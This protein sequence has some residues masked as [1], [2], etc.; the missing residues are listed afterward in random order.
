MRE[1]TVNEIDKVSGGLDADGVSVGLGALALGV[2]IVAT[3]GL[4]TVP[5]S[6]VL[7]AATIGELGIAGAGLALSGA[8]GFMIGDSLQDDDGK[9]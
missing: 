2:A 4:A 1:L 7:G 3:A 5:V 9:S 6:I 8:G